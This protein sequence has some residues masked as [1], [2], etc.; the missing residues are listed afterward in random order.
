MSREKIIERV[1]KLLAL[2][3]SSNEHEAALAAFHAQRLLSEHN[4]NISELEIKETGA[5]ETKFKLRQMTADKWVI[6]LL[7]AVARS[8]DCKTMF[9]SNGLDKASVMVIGCGKDSEVA[10]YVMQ[11]L[12]REINRLATLYVK[13]LTTAFN[14]NKQ[15]YRKS[16]LLGAS[17]GVISKL[18]EQKKEAPVT[19][20]ALVPVKDA[21]VTNYVSKHYADASAKKFRASSVFRDAF[22]QGFSEGKDV[23]ISKGIAD[24]Q[25]NHLSLP[26]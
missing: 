2:S 12:L 5:T 15:A 18:A 4:L 17:R 9:C 11:Y 16:Y 14:I 7:S 19:S 13:S 23:Q 25:H 22:D 26:N 3:K 21:L 24:E 8:F 10:S 1:Q 6:L 20:T